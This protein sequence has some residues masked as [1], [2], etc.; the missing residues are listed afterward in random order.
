MWF[1]PSHL[2]ETKT[3]SPAIFA[4]PAIPESTNLNI[5]ALNNLSS[6]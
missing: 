5:G 1:N 3:D 6:G 2:L 4:I